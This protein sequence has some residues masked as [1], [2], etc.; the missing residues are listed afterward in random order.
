MNIAPRPYRDER[1]LESARNILVAGRRA[2]APVY[3]VHIGDLNWW[4]FYI[5]QDFSQRLYLWESDYNGCAMGWV[6]FSPRFGAFDVFVY[7]DQSLNE[8][9]KSLFIWAEEQMGRTVSAQ[10]G[11]NLRTMWVSEHDYQL[12]THLESR[13]FVQSEYH[14]IYMQRNLDE[15][16]A[17]SR[18]PQD[19]YLRHVVGEHEVEQR[20]RVSYAAFESGKPFEQYLAGTLRFMRSSVYRPELDLVVVSPGGQF[21]AFCICWLDETNQEGYFEPVGTH[22]DFRRQGLGKAIVTEGLRR[23]KARGMRIA[24]VCVE[25]DNPTAQKLYESAGFRRLHKLHTYVKAL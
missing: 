9:R 16:I 10:G 4:L 13:G 24:S 7:P 6:L 8:Q 18:L 23:M 5:D 14:M 25:S 19:Y 20:A 12:I 11:K 3:Y 15:I 21:A 2:V 1:D 22:P 17:E